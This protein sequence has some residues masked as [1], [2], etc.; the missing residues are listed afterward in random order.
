[1]DGQLC[2]YTNSKPLNC[3]LQMGELYGVQI[4]TQ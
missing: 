2:E 1:M 4:I 3:V